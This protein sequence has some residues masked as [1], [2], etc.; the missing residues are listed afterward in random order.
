MRDSTSFLLPSKLAENLSGNRSTNS[1]ATFF[2][3]SGRTL[4]KPSLALHVELSSFPHNRRSWI[5]MLHFSPS[6]NT[7][8]L[9]ALRK[10]RQTTESNYRTT[11]INGIIHLILGEMRVSSC[12]FLNGQSA[13]ELESTI[14]LSH[15]GFPSRYSVKNF[16]NSGLDEYSPET[17]SFTRISRVLVMD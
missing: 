17:S 10:A 14:Y 6:F 11:S 3:R 9:M 7:Y 15:R 12:S 13:V 16:A 2:T 8:V 4:P 1:R 5:L